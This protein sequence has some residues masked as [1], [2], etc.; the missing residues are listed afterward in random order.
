MK[1]RS[2]SLSICCFSSPAMRR[3]G[4]ARRGGRQFRGAAL[5]P[6]TAGRV[7][8]HAD[9]T[10]GDAGRGAARHQLVQR[11]VEGHAE[12]EQRDVQAVHKAQHVRSRCARAEAQRRRHAQQQRLQ[13]P[14]LDGA[15]RGRGGAG[16]AKSAQR[17]VSTPCDVTGA[18]AKRRGLLAAPGPSTGNV[19]PRSWCS[20]G[21]M[22]PSPPRTRAVVVLGPE[23]HELLQ[24]LA[25][26]LP[27][28]LLVLLLEV[29]DDDRREEVQHHDGHQ[30]DE[31]EEEGDGA[32]V[33]AL[34]TLA[35]GRLHAHP[36]H[37]VD[38]VVTRGHPAAATAEVRRREG[39]RLRLRGKEGAHKQTGGMRRGP[40]SQCAPSC[41]LRCAHLRARARAHRNSVSSASA[42][43]LKLA[44]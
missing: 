26:Q 27:L 35:G 10:L 18:R 19:Q 31:A 2:V 29:L 42:K 36:V 25:R 23:V 21:A 11:L 33:A 9:R 1:W 12:V 13:L 44:W 30:E 34:V 28:L 15:C 38:P 37:H 39:G 6:C 32:L 40:L 22:G 17:R 7:K 41:A 8:E 3:K 5:T 20:S 16:A 4:R 43:L 24:R 14:R